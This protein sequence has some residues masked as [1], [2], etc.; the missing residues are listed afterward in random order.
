MRWSPGLNLLTGKNGA[1]KTNILEGIS[2][3]SGWGPF[4]SGAKRT[5]L[6][7]WESGSTEVQFTCEL[8]GGE[9]IKVKSAKRMTLRV[10]EKAATASELR[11]L[12]PALAFLPDDMAL[13]EGSSASRRHL[14]DMLLAIIVPSYALRLSEYR[15]G[16]RQKA[17]FLKRGMPSMIVDRAL[18]PLAA[19]IWKMRAEGVKL[20]YDCICGISDL[21]PAHIELSLKRGGAGLCPDFEDDYAKSV[22]AMRER[23][24]ALRF[25]V[26]GPHRDDMLITCEGM[27]ASERFSRGLR[28]RTAI[29]LML[30]ACDAVKRKTGTAPVLL[31]DEV[32][33]ELDDEGRSLLFDSLLARGT[34]VFAATAEPIKRNFP[35]AVYEIAEGAVSECEKA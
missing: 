29:A 21:T 19:W 12:V 30:A 16:I 20:L 32:A 14:L 6:A 27:A 5:Q 1:G 23:E 4:E 13:I 11:R 31:L 10:D 22:M 17:L 34:Q 28:R 8:S 15:R 33:S 26:V 7:K 2:I 9:I 18:L 35:G 25:P 24:C 3:I